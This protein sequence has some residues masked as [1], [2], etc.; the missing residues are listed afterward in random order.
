V[1][2]VLVFSFVLARIWKNNGSE[3]IFHKLLFP[4]LLQ[5]ILLNLSSF[6]AKW[7]AFLNQL[8]KW[9][10]RQ[11]WFY[12]KRFQEIMP[13]SKNSKDQI[14]KLKKTTGTRSTS[15]QLLQ[16]RLHC[17]YHITNGQYL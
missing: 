9:I 8:A 1:G 3:I 12:F 16:N 17:M 14:L 11:Q 15:S 2:V 7:K 6:V 10:Y 4:S 5:L 13:A